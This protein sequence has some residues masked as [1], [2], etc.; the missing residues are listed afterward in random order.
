M[1]HTYRHLL[2]MPNFSIINNSFAGLETD[3]AWTGCTDS[4]RFRVIH[5]AVEFEKFGSD[6]SRNN[7]LRNTL[8]IG[9]DDFLVGGVFRVTAVKRPM[10]W[11]E[12]ARLVADLRKDVHFAILG[13]GDMA[14]AMRRYAQGHGFADRLHMPGLVSDVGAWYRA[15]D[16]NLLTSER[17]GLPNVLIEGQHFGVPA[18]SAD[19]GG[20]FETVEPGSTGFL[21]APDAGASAYADAIQRILSD[22]E[23][24]RTARVRGPVFVHGKFGMERAVE[25]VLGCLGMA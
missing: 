7:G 25:A 19:V 1:Q 21:I 16:I 14:A 13:D 18:V 9:P 4:S 17:E 8:G 11:I 5:N 10:L 15:M 24:R 6:N 20:A 12:A 23:W 2:S 22:A 3:Q